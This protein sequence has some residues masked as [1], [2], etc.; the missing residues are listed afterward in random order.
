MIR[1][2]TIIACLLLGACMVGPDY[3]RPEI[4]VA[5][6]WHTDLDKKEVAEASLAD[7][8]W[9]DIFKDGQLQNILQQS[10]AQNKF[11]LIAMERIEESRALYRVGRAPL[12]PTL[13]IAVTGERE[14]ESGLVEADPRIAPEY[15]LGAAASWELDLWGKN[16]RRSNAA[17]ARYLAS[18]Y[19]AQA[20][21]LAVIAE[22]SRAYFNLQGTNSRLGVNYATLDAREQ[23]VTIAEKR[24]RGGLTSSL[25]VKQAEVERAATASTIPRIEQTKL[26]TENR[27]AVLMGLPPQH[28]EVTGAL[29]DQFIP[30]KVTAGLPSE[31]LER[32]PDLMAAEQEL[33]AASESVGVAKA[34]LF[35]SISLTGAAGYQTEEFGDLLDSDGK[36][37]ILNVDL[38]MPLFNAG[39]RRAQL[40]AAES[41]F[42]QTRL[43]YEQIVLDAL[44]ETSDALNNFY[45]SGEALE[46]ALDLERASS[47]YLVLATK[48][49][50]NGVLNYLDVLDA[51]RLL[52][53]AQISASLA[54]E[55]QLLALVDLYKALG[56][57]W[58]PENFVPVEERD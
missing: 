15:F 14:S 22:V 5:E 45:K 36:Y 3:Q 25:E 48:R 53:E 26:A 28:L 54:R 18:E 7:Q 9:L 49:Y 37:W 58:E 29:E 30:A 31:L 51:Q 57:G 1:T 24:H 4:P 17:Y 21:K 20:V 46:A 2:T 43:A 56:G 35:P 42:N 13:D 52:F 6:D 40:T 11:M 19:G 12:F 50:R 47:E 34:R 16:R 32:R 27:L 55:D 8:A 44:R 23:S 33:I 10:L 41:R 38:V 39:A